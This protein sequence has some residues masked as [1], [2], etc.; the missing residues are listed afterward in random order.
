MAPRC[1]HPAALIAL[2]L[3]GLVALLLLTITTEDVREAPVFMYGIVLDAGSS[4]TALYIYKWPADKQNGT[5]VVTQ[6]GECRVHGKVR[7]HS[8]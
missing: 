3:F 6:H 5:G 8:R 2:L 1:A 4:H 7:S